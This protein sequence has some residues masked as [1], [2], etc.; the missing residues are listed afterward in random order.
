MGVLKFIAAALALGM[1]VPL[2]VPVAAAP[3]TAGGLMRQELAAASARYGLDEA[4]LLD[5]VIE[6]ETLREDG[7]VEKSLVR[8]GDFVA[9]LDDDGVSAPG[10]GGLPETTA[11]DFLH[12]Y[13]NVRY[14][15]SALAYTVSTSTVVPATPLTV[16]PPPATAYFFDVG[17]PTRNVRG[18]YDLGL[19]TVGT[20]VGSNVDTASSGPYLPTQSTG[21]VLENRIDFV[22]HAIVSQ[23]E[24]CFSTVCIAIGSMLATGAA[25]WDTTTPALPTL[26]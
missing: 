4:M 22:G 25:T 15:T 12:F 19:H 7:S 1:L 18:A 5:T 23:G 8:V 21:I 2:A 17:G 10:I 14:G 9:A 20:L 13:F 11:G 26:P 16:L 24:T 3:P 6:V